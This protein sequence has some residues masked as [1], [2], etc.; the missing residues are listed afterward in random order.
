M[1]EQEQQTADTRRDPRLIVL[2]AM[3]LH[4]IYLFKH[5]YREAERQLRR[6]DVGGL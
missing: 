5:A 4:P 2:L 3:A 1:N 6:P